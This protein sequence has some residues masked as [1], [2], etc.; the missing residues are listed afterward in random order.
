MAALARLTLRISKEE[1][2]LTSVVARFTAKARDGISVSPI[3]PE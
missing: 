3:R 2:A 1:T